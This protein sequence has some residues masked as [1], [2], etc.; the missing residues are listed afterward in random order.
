[1]LKLKVAEV[2]SHFMS[3]FAG[4]VLPLQHMPKLRSSLKQQDLWFSQQSPRHAWG[5]LYFLPL[6]LAASFVRRMRSPHGLPRKETYEEL[7]LTLVALVERLF[8][9]DAPR[10][11]RVAAV[12]FAL[13]LLGAVVDSCPS[14]AELW[15]LSAQKA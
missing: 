8:V 11:L 12:S 10:G 15:K 7:S 2:E 13:A 4:H 5:V 3:F 14:R 6:H 1:M 9:L